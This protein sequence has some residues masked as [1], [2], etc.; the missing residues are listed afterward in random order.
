MMSYYSGGQTEGTNDFESSY[1]YPTQSPSLSLDEPANSYSPDTSTAN[2][3]SASEFEGD[4]Q[5]LL[6]STVHGTTSGNRLVLV[7]KGKVSKYFLKKGSYEI[8]QQ[9]VTKAVE[10][11][12]KYQAKRGE[13]QPGPTN[14]LLAALRTDPVKRLFKDANDWLQCSSLNEETSRR[15]YGMSLESLQKKA[16]GL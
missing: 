13:L 11:Y 7:D 2:A 5:Q 4:T 14:R 16:K 8:V 15:N 6:P 10:R 9:D 1:T 3:Y 12:E